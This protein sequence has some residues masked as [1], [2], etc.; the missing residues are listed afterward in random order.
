M[1]TTSEF[2]NTGSFQLPGDIG[3]RAEFEKDEK[4]YPRQLGKLYVDGNWY[5]VEQARAL[6][7]FLNEVL[8]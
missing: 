3:V 1:A 2:R 7:D 8:P 6:R 5:T 4:Q